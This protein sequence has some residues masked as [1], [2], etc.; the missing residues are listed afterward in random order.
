[1]ENRKRRIAITQGDTNSIGYEII[2]K[3]FDDPTML[4][5][6][7]PIIYGS[8][9]IATYHRNALQMQVNFAVIDRAEDAHDGQLNILNCID[10]DVKIELGIHTEEAG[11][12]ALKALD[13][14]IDDCRQGE[15]D[16]MVTCPVDSSEAFRFSG[17]TRYIEDH[18]G[19]F[20]SALN[21]YVTNAMRLAVASGNVPLR[22]VAA[23]INEQHL[24]KIITTLHT[25]MR[26]DF[27]ISN[28]RIA[29]LSVNPGL[30]L[31]PA[32]GSEE[33]AVLKPVVDKLKENSIQT[34]GPYVAE[35]FFAAG[36]H[37]AFDAVLAMYYDQGMA[38][39]RALSN[40]D[41]YRL[42]TG[43]PFVR[44]APD[45]N[46]CMKLAGKGE[47]D[48]SSLRK[49]IYAAIDTARNRRNYDIPLANPLKKLYKE[50][51]EE[52]DKP[53]F[54]QAKPKSPVQ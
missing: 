45:H 49:A 52:G 23:S 41:G 24:T 54:A 15:V 35:N 42:T 16:A 19:E 37:A 11:N 20:D 2:F 34:F 46:C 32:E 7:T 21:I 29:L 43:L 33:Q 27:G 13:R 31:T 5:L 17:Q 36:K 14:A 30:E 51:R 26:R 38:A 53:R 8:P 28:P 4:E 9:K 48:C 22:E 10:T 1:M 40:E 50:R 47:A 44:T 3:A 39:M 12:A 25:A 18:T 6:C